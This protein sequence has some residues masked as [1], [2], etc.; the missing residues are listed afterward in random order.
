M[1]KVITSFGF[2]EHSDMLSVAIPSFYRYASLHNYDC[3]FPGLD[4]FSDVTK[5]YPYSWWK[6]E[7]ITFL[8]HNYDI[9]LWLDSDV[10]I[11]DPLKDIAQDLDQ[12]CDIGMV[13][14]EVPIGQVPNCGIWILRSNALQWINDLWKYDNFIR[15]DGWWEQAAMLHKLGIDPDS[16]PVKIPEKTNIKFTSLDYRWNPHVHDHRGLPQDLRFLH[17]TMFNDRVASMKHIA[18]Q[19]GY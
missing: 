17:F 15:S 18:K 8:L 9:V 14:H 2:Q 7:A 12:D 4:F 10:I 13:V 16:D 5:N 3:F 6:L 11:C 19:L 1:K